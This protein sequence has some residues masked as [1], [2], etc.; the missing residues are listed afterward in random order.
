M[1][2]HSLII[3]P[4]LHWIGFL[5]FRFVVILNS[6][7]TLSY[8]GVAEWPKAPHLKCGKGEILS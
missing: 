5:L 1:H 4:F 3:N 6:R 2:M 7:Y 8:G